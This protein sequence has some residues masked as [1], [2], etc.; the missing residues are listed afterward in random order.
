M[1]LNDIQSQQDFRNLVVDK[2]GIKNI[3]YP[4]TLKDRAKGS[5]HTVATINAYV[6]LPHNFKGTHMSRFVEVL[7]S[8]R[9]NISITSFKEIL[10][11]LCK[12]LNSE[13]SHIEVY[14][15]YF[16]EKASPVSNYVS[17]MDYQCAFIGSKI[18]EEKDFILSV[19][20]PV[21]SVCPCSKEISRYG[22][23]NQ[24]SYVKINIR[25]CKMV[26]IEDLIEI[27]EKAASAPIYALLKRED[28]K[29]ITEKSYENPVFVEDIVR[30]VA[31]KLICDDRITWFEVSS[32]NQE[33][34][35]NHSAYAVITRDKSY[36]VR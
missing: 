13:E 3:L 31:E 20:V 29:Y 16:V 11:E 2:V 28:E 30:N 4:I 5:Q 25:Y 15:P 18:G 34:I 10:D 7:N 8:Y 24:R 26:W 33:S 12:R 27:A 1:S 21:L 19:S 9:D 14:F 6:Q 36:N 32:E 35:H 22:A 17:I 23:H